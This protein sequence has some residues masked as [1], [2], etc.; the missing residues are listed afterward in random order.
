MQNLK[1]ELS[2]YMKNKW[3]EKMYQEVKG[4]KREVNE[5]PVA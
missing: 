1:I 5:S 3:G 4:T 2:L